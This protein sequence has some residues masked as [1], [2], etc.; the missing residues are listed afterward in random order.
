MEQLENEARTD[1]VNAERKR[2]HDIDEVARMCPADMVAEAKYGANACDAKELTYRAM[3]ADAKRGAEYMQN[4]A[5]DVQNSGVQNVGSTAPADARA[6]EVNSPEA[7]AAAG[8]KDAQAFLNLM[9][10]K[11][12]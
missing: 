7:N 5:E 4:R 10:G 3:L 6:A 8:K 2:L 11:V 1:A 9:K 12:K